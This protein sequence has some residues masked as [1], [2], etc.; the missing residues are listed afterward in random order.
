[1]STKKLIVDW[2]G[3]LGFGHPFSRAHT[4][5]KMAA[6]ITVTRKLRDGT[7]EKWVIPNPD[8]FPKCTKLGP[9]RNSPVVWR[10]SDVLA[11]YEAH[12]LKVTED[13]NAS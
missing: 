1:M 9:H 2:I 13:Y 5:R 10:V 11:Y 12:G 3:L 6:T 7:Q 8:P 4:W